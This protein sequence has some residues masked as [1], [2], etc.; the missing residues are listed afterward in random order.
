MSSLIMPL[1]KVGSFGIQMPGVDVFNN[2]GDG[3]TK[4]KNYAREIGFTIISED[5]TSLTMRRKRCSKSNELHKPQQLNPEIDDDNDLMI[6]DQNSATQQQ[7]NPCPFRVHFVRREDGKWVVNRLN[8]YHN[9]TFRRRATV[10]GHA[11]KHSPT[12]DDIF[13]EEQKERTFKTKRINFKHLSYELKQHIDFLYF[14]CGMNRKLIKQQIS[15]QREVEKQHLEEYMGHFQCPTFSKVLEL[16][17]HL[18]KQQE[19]NKKFWYFYD[20]FQSMLCFTLLSQN[21][22]KL[23]SNV[24]MIDS[25]YDKGQYNIILFKGIDSFG[26]TIILYVCITPKY[27]QAYLFTAL[28]NYQMA[29]FPSPRCVIMDQG[30][31]YKEAFDKI[32]FKPESF[33]LCQNHVLS[34]LKK[35]LVDPET[36]FSRVEVKNTLALIKKIINM[37]TQD[38][39]T[40]QFNEVYKKYRDRSS[41]LKKTLMNL[42]QTKKYFA[43]SLV[44][45][46]YNF[47]KLYT[48]M[49]G[50]DLSIILKR[51]PQR[52]GTFLDFYNFLQLHLKKCKDHIRI[53]RMKLTDP[54]TVGQKEPYISIIDRGEPIIGSLGLLEQ[55]SQSN[56]H[57][58]EIQK[59]FIPLKTYSRQRVSRDKREKYKSL[60]RAIAW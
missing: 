39:L 37:P 1:D 25:H 4:V 13:T 19:V 34:I 33:Q 9:H 53:T 5:K 49:K 56:W 45:S 14:E 29:G 32:N 48:S 22:R 26:H 42:F 20:D 43:K 60:L 36:G 8:T 23:Y 27:D 10:V 57:N 21:K 58:L 47:D 38:D 7:A 54:F 55:K 24:L 31:E 41:G 2:F 51:T 59:S 15:R 52:N 18:Q 11:L 35:T 28:E 44:T 6:I 30:I 17:D 12:E 46:N 40:S 3:L 16:R 50:N